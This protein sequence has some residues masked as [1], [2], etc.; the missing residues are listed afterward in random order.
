MV[1]M[2]STNAT[3]RFGIYRSAEESKKGAIATECKRK[4]CILAN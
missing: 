1:S 3:V 2:Q 4:E